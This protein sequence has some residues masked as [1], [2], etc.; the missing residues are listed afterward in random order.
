MFRPRLPLVPSAGLGKSLALKMPLMYL[1]RSR[2]P[3]LLPNA[4]KLGRSLVSPLA[5]QSQVRKGRLAEDGKRQP[6]PQLHDAV[7]LP[8]S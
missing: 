8:V 1:E 4:G 2:L 7:E 5:F 3:S 6:G